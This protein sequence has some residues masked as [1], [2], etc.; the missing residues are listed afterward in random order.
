MK[1]RIL[2]SSD[3]ERDIDEQAVYIAQDSP[4]AALRYYRSLWAGFKRLLE[5]PEIGVR[6]PTQEPKLSDLRF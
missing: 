1:A 2:L 5:M 3:A 6:Y 4:R